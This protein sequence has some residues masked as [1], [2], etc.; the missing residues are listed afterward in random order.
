MKSALLAGVSLI[1]IIAAVILSSLSVDGVLA[2]MESEIGEKNITEN[3]VEK[4]KREFEDGHF[5]L[6]ISLSDG[7]IWEIEDRINELEEA[8]KLGGEENILKAK[9][10]LVNLLKRQRR[11]SL[12]DP[13]SVF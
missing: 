6:S 11:L 8:V 5:R 7:A 10:R 2:R 4:L 1:V 9:S 13:I 3:D 12:F